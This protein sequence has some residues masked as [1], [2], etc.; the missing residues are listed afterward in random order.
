MSKIENIGLNTIGDIGTLSGKESDTINIS[1][2]NNNGIVVIEFLFSTAITVAG[3]RIKL[4]QSIDGEHF[5]SVRDHYSSEIEI[6]FPVIST[7]KA[8]IA[9]FA[10]VHATYIKVYGSGNGTN[11]VISSIKAILK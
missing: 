7:D 9:S 11:G 1:S 4:L 10:N 8:F 2:H 6:T 3:G 5:D